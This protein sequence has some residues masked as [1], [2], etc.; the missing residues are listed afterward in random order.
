M[1][2]KNEIVLIGAGKIGKAYVA[3]VFDNA[4]YDITFIGRSPQGIQLLKKQG[5]YTVHLSYPNGQK[6]MRRIDGYEAFSY[7]VEREKCIDRLLEVDLACVQI[8]PDGVND[9][10][11]LL[12]EAIMQRADAAIDRP[13]NV[14]FC[15][16]F[17]LPSRMFRARIAKQMH[18]EKHIRY[19]D[20]KIGFVDGLPKRGVYAPTEQM[21]CDDPLALNANVFEEVIPVGKTF[22]GPLP[23]TK[24]LRFVDHA[25]GLIVQKIWCGNMASS[26]L[27][28]LG[29]VLKQAIYMDEAAQDS[30]IR[31]IVDGAREEACRAVQAEY[32]FTEE[33]MQPVK[34][35]NWAALMQ[36]GA[37]DTVKRQANDP[38]RKLAKN[39]RF[40]GPGLLCIKHGGIPVFL[41]RGAAAIFLYDNKEDEKAVALQQYIKEYGIDNAIEEHCQLDMKQT[42]E[43]L[44]KQLIMKQYADL[45]ALRRRKCKSS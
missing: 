10:V 40:T 27:G 1:R 5:Y 33:E 32:E 6:K 12:A 7:L 25:E 28:A 14:M 38:I 11:D 36:P 34:N 45:D 30:Y 22:V 37:R 20:S 23:D 43:V 35:A 18:T 8:Y 21:L 9:A 41:A 44:W 2:R 19:F 31:F 26:M 16:N 3:E 17:V 42:D 39:E 15:V 29:F 24:A 13:L 4:G